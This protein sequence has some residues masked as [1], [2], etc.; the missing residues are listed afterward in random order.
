MKRLRTLQLLLAALASSAVAG[1]W[2][3]AVTYEIFVRAFA[4]SN[5]DGTGDLRGVTEKLDYLKDLGVQAI[6]LMPI[7]PSPSYH[8]YDVTDYR[9][10]H[11]EYGTMKDFETLIAEAHRRGIRIIIDLVINHTSRQHPWFEAAVTDPSGPYRDYY[12]WRHADEIDSMTASSAGP[13]TDNLRRWHEAGKDTDSFYYAYFTGGMPD[14]NFD[15]PEVRREIYDIGRFWLEKGVDGFRLD[16]AMHIYPDERED[17]SVAFWK[18]FRREMEKTNPDVLLVGEVWTEGDRAKKYLPGLKS[19]FNFELAGSILDALRSGR[20]DGLAA[21]HADLQ[22]K[23]HG[24]TGDFVDA[25]FLSNHDQNRVMSVLDDEDRARVAAAILLTLPGSPYLYYGEEIGMLGTKPDHF[26]REPMLWQKQ[27]DPWRAQ[28]GRV[29]FNKSSAVRPVQQQLENP[30]SLLNHYRSLIH[31]R[32]KTAALNRGDL[33]PVGDLHPSLVAFIRRQD[34]ERVLVAHN[35]SGKRVVIDL[36]ETFK[37][38]TEVLWKSSDRVAGKG[39]TITLPAHS[40]IVLRA[41][42]S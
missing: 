35:V 34:N 1:E 33:Q 22:R 17:D 29:R 5:K 12:V 28:T 37:G 18:E 30:S 36:P 24:V 4:D 6:W 16:A 13:D 39:A 11:P 26:I 2:P 23:Y 8:K 19:V 21:R 10:I 7:H 25:T 15:N 27:P 3:H 41:R 42:A 38:F 9:E 14:L 32:N 40:S 31:L 20:G